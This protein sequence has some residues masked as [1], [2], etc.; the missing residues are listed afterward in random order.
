MYIRY[1]CSRHNKFLNNFKKEIITQNVITVSAPFGG[2]KYHP[3]FGVK[4]QWHLKE[5]SLSKL[6]IRISFLP[7]YIILIACNALNSIKY[8]EKCI[9]ADNTNTCT[10][11][12]KSLQDP[13]AFLLIL[14]SSSSI[15]RTVRL[16]KLSFWTLVPCCA[17]FG[18][19]SSQNP[20]KI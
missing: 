12:V 16:D 11:Q 2:P 4:K 17:L 10:C 20:S 8:H 7:K 3:R 15:S 6:H 9:I 1:A 5:V 13:H 19:F 18:F 14:L